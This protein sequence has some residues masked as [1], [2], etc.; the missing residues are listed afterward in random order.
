MYSTILEALR[1]LALTEGLPF[2]KN[3]LKK[4]LDE[5]NNYINS[6]NIDITEADTLIDLILD[7]S[8][9]L[10]N[11]LDLESY[12]NNAE[13]LL[14]NYILEESSI[15]NLTFAYSADTKDFKED[16]SYFEIYLVK[17][18]DLSEFKSSGVLSKLQTCLE[19]LLEIE[20]EDKIKFFLQS[21]LKGGSYPLGSGQISGAIKYQAN[22]NNN[23][24][25]KEGYFPIELRIN[26][27]SGDKSKKRIYG[28]MTNED[29]IRHK[30]QIYLVKSYIKNSGQVDAD[31]DF[32]NFIKT[33]NKITD[34]SNN[35]TKYCI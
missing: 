23:L 26:S 22:A 19:A 15:D 9:K 3:N 1:L 16:N 14:I 30:R 20:S 24:K 10:K 27:N 35:S 18:L 7:W 32:D 13:E 28:V 5:F 34:L 17:T 31:L 25:I 4:F 8:D 29:P 21:I 33:F 12:G 11:S 2:T 6:N